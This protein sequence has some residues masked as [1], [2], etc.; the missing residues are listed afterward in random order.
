MIEALKPLRSQLGAVKKIIFNRP[1][2]LKCMGKNS[3]VLHPRLM[4]GRAH[5]TLGTRSVVMNGCRIQAICKYGSQVFAPSISIG[6]DVYIGH[7][8]FIAAIEEIRI[9]NGCVFSD[10]VYLND[11]SHGIDPANGLI[12]L[13][14]LESKGP[15]H[16]GMNCFLGYRVAVMPAVTL[17]DWCIVG[18]NSVVTRSFPPYSMIGGAPARLIRRYSPEQGKWISI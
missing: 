15:I 6:D 4:S 5:I 17:G 9:G 14:N 8:S 18:A 16:I 13:Q 10:Y 1:L 11:S 3:A 7:Y 12:M 2:G